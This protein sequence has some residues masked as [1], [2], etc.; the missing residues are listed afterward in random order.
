MFWPKYSMAEPIRAAAVKKYLLI[1]KL[2]GLAVSYRDFHQPWASSLF[3]HGLDLSFIVLLLWVLE[4]F[5]VNK[6]AAKYK[7]QLFICLHITF[8]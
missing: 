6:G 8:V 2:Q 7:S 3:V 1:L 4:F 5:L